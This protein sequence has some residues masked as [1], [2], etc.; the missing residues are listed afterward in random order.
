[1]EIVA[2]NHSEVMEQRLK[3]FEVLI[4]YVQT[5]QVKERNLSL[6]EM[7]LMTGKTKIFVKSALESFQQKG[8]ITI[9]HNRI[10]INKMALKW[11]R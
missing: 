11:K 10:I 8:S 3:L 4:R 9:E 7:A 5:V 2:V 1:L 6:S